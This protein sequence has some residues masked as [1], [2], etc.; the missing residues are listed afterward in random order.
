[1]PA[2]RTTHRLYGATRPGLTEARGW[3]GYRVTDNLGSGL[4]RLEDVWVDAD[5]GDPAWLL[6]KEGRFGNGR[7]KLVPFG[8]S[9][10]GGGQVWLPYERQT[11]RSSPEIG[12]QEILT[13][14]LGERLRAHYQDHHL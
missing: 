2:A 13:A 9:T 8:G 10:A 14:S 7:H 6:I 12:E 3:I 4:G 11:V 5:T 1:M